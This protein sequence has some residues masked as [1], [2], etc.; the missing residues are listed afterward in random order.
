MLAGA[1]VLG[2]VV[3]AQEPPAADP[4][5][6]IQLQPNFY[7]IG[8]AGSNIAVQIGPE[9]VVVVDSGSS[10]MADAVIAV[11]KRLTDQPIRYIINTGP[12]ADH[13]SGNEK[14]ARAGRALGTGATTAAAASGAGII[15][16]EGVLNRM[17]ATT[18]TGAPYPVKAWPTESF[19]RKQKALYLNNEAIVVMLQPAA[20]SDGDSLVFFRRSDIVVTGDVLDTTRFPVIE[21]EHGGSVQG[22]IDALNRLI[23]IVVPSIPLAYKEGGTRVI[24]GHGRICE[25][26]E[27]VEYRD[28]LTIIRN[29]IQRLIGKGMT[30]EQVKAANPTQ[31]Y[32]SRYGSD[33]GAWTTDMFVEAVY[34]GLTIKKS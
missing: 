7:M 2:D 20:H 21:V 9:G 4:L 3:A 1:V 12:D 14:I 13:V 17:S 15:A 24:P 16:S 10:E 5:E 27:I 33:S 6:V 18:G 32:R 11:I 25:Q 19:S 28:M 8:G 31:G 30:L 22:E 26:A 29:T 34:K 23:D